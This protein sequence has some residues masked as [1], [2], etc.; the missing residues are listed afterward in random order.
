MLF[1]THNVLG[2]G[3]SYVSPKDPKRTRSRQNRKSPAVAKNMAVGEEKK[4]V[5]VL[6]QAKLA[7]EHDGLAFRNAWVRKDVDM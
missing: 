6:S 1:P 5:S 7:G 4:D 3:F 2:L